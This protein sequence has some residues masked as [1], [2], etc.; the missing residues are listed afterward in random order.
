MRRSRRAK[1]SQKIPKKSPCLLTK[2]SPQSWTVD[3]T[4]KLQRSSKCRLRVAGVVFWSST[5]PTAACWR[6]SVATS[7]RM[8]WSSSTDGDRIDQVTRHGTWTKTESSEAWSTIS[9]SNLRVC[10]LRVIDACV[11]C[12]VSPVIVLH[13]FT[14]RGALLVHGRA[15]HSMLLFHWLN[16]TEKPEVFIHKTVRLTCQL[17]LSSARLRNYASL[18]RNPP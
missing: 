12:A 3:T 14:W 15:M 4:F 1:F 9:P 2:K 6:Y 10:R 5:R 7:N 16:R 11:W 8:H 13:L 18:D 17:T